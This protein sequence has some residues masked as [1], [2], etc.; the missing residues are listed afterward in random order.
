[1]VKGRSVTGLYRQNVGR[2][3]III[4]ALTVVAPIFHKLS[5]RVSGDEIEAEIAQLRERIDQLEKKRAAINPALAD[6]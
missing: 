6:L 4:G 1:M 2:P 5:S 3:S